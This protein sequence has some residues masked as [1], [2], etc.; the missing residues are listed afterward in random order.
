MLLTFVEMAQR[1]EEAAII[2]ITRQVDA[3]AQIYPDHKSFTMLIS[4][5]I[6]AITLL[7]L[8]RKLNRVI[9]YGVGGRVSGKGLVTVK[10]L[11]TKNT[12]NTEMNLYPLADQSAVQVLDSRRYSVA[13]S[14]I[15]RC[16]K[17]RG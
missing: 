9:E 4:H 8:G 16:E 15:S 12:L 10:D 1:L 6:A 5:G 11:F 7:S 14:K 17:R 13:E 3:C 2:H